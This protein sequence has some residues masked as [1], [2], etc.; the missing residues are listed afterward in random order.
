MSSLVVKQFFTALVL[1]SVVD[2]LWI[3]L[4]ANRF[5][6]KQF[7]DLA[8][9][10]NGKFSVVYWAAAGVYLLLALATTALVVPLAAD[11]IR[12]AFL[13]GAL[14]GFCLYGVYDLTN[15]ATLRR[16]PIALLSMDMAW[17]TFLC[18]T[19]SAATIW[20]SLNFY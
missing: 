6:L 1:F 4:I 19:V 17:G 10:R 16:W 12:S 9:Q 13:Y 3:G 18:G 14:V 5:Y 11:G 7:G 15:H 20:I 8:R 2:F